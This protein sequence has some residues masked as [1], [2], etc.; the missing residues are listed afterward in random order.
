MLLYIFSSLIFI[1]FVF[2][3][4]FFLIT[5]YKVTEEMALNITFQCDFSQIYGTLESTDIG[6]IYRLIDHI[7]I[8][9]R[10]TII[11]TFLS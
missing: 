3:K 9:V 1:I 6:I 10:L 5:K 2:F 8:H 7:N 11:S 4:V